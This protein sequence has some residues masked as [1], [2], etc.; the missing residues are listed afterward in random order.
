MFISWYLVGQ[1]LLASTETQM[2][3][4]NHQNKADKNFKLL[5]WQANYYSE[6]KCYA[7]DRKVLT[8]F[9]NLG[10]SI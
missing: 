4:Q 9:E 7:T 8:K 1:I 3:S 10:E 6:T 2:I 5:K